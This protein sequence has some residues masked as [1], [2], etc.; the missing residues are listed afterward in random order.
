MNTPVRGSGQVEPVTD[1]MSTGQ[2]RRK[3]FSRTTRMMHRPNNDGRNAQR[4]RYRRGRAG[5]LRFKRLV[6]RQ[7]R[8]QL[9][10]QTTFEDLHHLLN[11]LR[12]LAERGQVARQSCTEEYSRQHSTLSVSKL[13]C[14]FFEESFM[15]KANQ[16]V[17]MMV[18]TIKSMYSRH[19]KV[20]T[21]F[22]A[23]QC[24]LRCM[25]GELRFRPFELLAFQIYVDF[26]IEETQGT[27][28]RH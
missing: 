18:H 13:L 26:L 25:L 16:T 8:S 11:R 27:R 22:P 28:Y 19:S 6:A 20:D 17:N 14:L 4:V 3:K 23:H 12:S 9:P 1:D 7:S 2:S 21:I 24:M 5:G 10:R 15:Y